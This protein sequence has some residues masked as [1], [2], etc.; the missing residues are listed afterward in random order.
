VRIS[1]VGIA[2]AGALATAFANAS[3]ELGHEGAVVKA[4]ELVAGSRALFLTRSLGAEAFVAKPFL[5]RLRHD[6]TSARPHFVIVV[7]G[8][9]LRAEA[10]NALRDDLGV[11]V[12]NYYPDHPLWPG[13]DDPQIVDSLAAYDEVLIWGEH[14]RDALVAAGVSSVRVVPFGYD[15]TVYRPPDAPSPHR[16]E[17]AVIGQ[18]YPERMRYAEALAEFDL[19]I[20]GKG[21]TRAVKQGPL[22]GRASDESFMGDE[23]CRLYWRSAIGLNILANW[24]V[25]AHNMRTFEVPATGTVMVGTQTPEHKA[26]FGSEGAV[27]VSGPAEAREAVR[28]LLA[29]PDR[30]AA[31]GAEGRRRVEPHTYASRLRTLLAPWRPSEESA[32]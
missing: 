28:T 23:T 15:P 18:S 32:S 7:K 13:H 14:V 16:W 31:I 27:L 20:S 3:T 17:I 11:P 26:I 9:F 8:R 21:W 24:N 10:I 30:L 29:D 5:D 4:P 12:V 6:L 1:V 25:P 2:G 19:L 22:R